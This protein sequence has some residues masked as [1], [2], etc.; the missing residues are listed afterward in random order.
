MTP[1]WSPSQNLIDTCYL[2]NFM[3]HVSKQHGVTFDDYAAFWQWSIDEMETFWS[4]F[5]EF[6]DI[7][8]QTKGKRVLVDGTDRA[9]MPMFKAR[10]FPDAHLNFAE[11]LL[12]CRDDRQ[13]IFFRAEDKVER[14]LSY[15][16][17]YQAVAKLA[18]AMKA[19]GIE[20]GD[21]VAGFVPNMPETV[22]AML[23]TTALGAIWTSC[24]PDFGALGVIDRFGQSQPKLLFTADGYYYNGK[25]VD[26]LSNV[27]SWIGDLPS[28]EQVVV[29]PLISSS[30]DLSSLS[31]A[32]NAATLEEFCHAI[33]TIKD[34][35]TIPFVQVEFNAPLYIM[36]SSG[37]TGKPKCIT[38]SVGGVLLMQLKEHLL[39]CNTHPQDRVFYFTTC[40]WMMWNWLVSALATKAC[41]MLYDGSPTIKNG[42]VLFDY[43]EEQDFTMFGTSAKFIDS[44]AKMNLSPRH[45]KRYSFSNLRLICS[46]GSPLAPE[47]FDFVYKHIKEEVQLSSISGGTDLLACFVTSSPILPVYRGEIQAKALGTAVAV[48]DDNGNKVKDEKGEL[49][50]TKPFPSMPL[51]FWNDPDDEKYFEAYFAKYPNCWAH[52]DYL[53]ESSQTGGFIISGR[54]DTTLNPGGVRIGTGEIYRQ[55]ESFSQIAESIVIGQEWQNDTRIVLFVRMQPTATLIPELVDAIKQRIRQNCTPRHVPAKI[56][57]VEDIP[58]T[59]SGKITELAVRDVVHGN[60]VKNKEALLNPE[61]LELYKDIDGLWD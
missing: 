43:A 39:H 41:L 54:S 4:D 35:D 48:F 51:M 29:L 58:R 25:T 18:E 61:A 19:M 13:A 9:D 47:G 56:F 40:G 7:R 44:C 17:L 10:F 45:D 34:E 2:T 6:A 8:A 24:S 28:V 33:P 38:H 23:A 52:G 21:R 32:C 16:E 42:Y 11:N 20:K 59:R 3:Q 57:A 31:S 53:M 46:T 36:Y 5:W 49:V 22:I 55:V 14:Q 50:C 15:K 60:P 30:P 12:R 27:Q 1:I 37:T 26:S